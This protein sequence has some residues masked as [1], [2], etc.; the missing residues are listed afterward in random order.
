MERRISEQILEHLFGIF[1]RS[2]VDSPRPADREFVIA[3]HVENADLRDRGGEK[4]GPLRER[5]A[6]EQTA[7]R[8]AVDRER[9]FRRVAFL[10]KE[11]R[12]GNEV[13]KDVLLLQF[14]ARLV[15][16]FAVL[17]AAAQNRD[18]VHAAAIEIRYADRFKARRHIDV[19]PA[20]SVERRR[21][22]A[23]FF[24]ALLIGDE[25]GGADAVR[26]FVPEPFGDVIVR[27]ESGV[28][29]PVEGRFVRLEVVTVDRRGI[30]NRRER[31]KH[32][33]EVRLAGEARDAKTGQFQLVEFRAVVAVEDAF[34]GGVFEERREEPVADRGDAGEQHVGFRYDV[35]PLLRVRLG[36]IDGDEPAVRGLI[37]GQEIELT[38]ARDD[39]ARFRAEV[40]KERLEFEFRVVALAAQVGEENAAS[41]GR[42]GL[43][44]EEPVFVVVDPRAAVPGRIVGVDENENVVLLRIADFMIVNFL[45]FILSGE[46]FAFGRRVVP[47][48]EEPV[49]G[50]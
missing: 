10:N 31:I 42:F 25:D 15:P 8:A 39:A 6:D 32:F 37:V 7:V 48:V 22:L 49:A 4:V 43:I 30:D 36:G 20:V 19:E 21:V 44:D 35:L 5:R 3:E 26:T 41:V 27:I 1:A 13:V 34:V 24:Q 14:R 46:L 38:A 12:R 47:A 11:F 23:V 2:V 50:P 17:S 29:L 9:L 33:V 18:R 28:R 40:G 45:I 16:F